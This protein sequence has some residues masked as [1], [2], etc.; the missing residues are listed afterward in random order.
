MND[1]QQALNQPFLQKNIIIM[2]MA[3]CCCFVNEDY[4]MTLFCLNSLVADARKADPTQR[5]VCEE[6]PVRLQPDA[7]SDHSPLAHLVMYTSAGAL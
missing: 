1:F 7:L 4:G 2:S 5:S 6:G 3:L